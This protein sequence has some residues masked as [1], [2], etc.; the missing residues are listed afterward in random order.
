MEQ[1]VAE[2]HFTPQ[3]LGELWHVDPNTIRRM[4]ANEDGVLVFGNPERRSHRRYYS[5]RIPTSVAARV[6][7]RLHERVQ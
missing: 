7:R 3:E 1:L 4:F 6:H 5:M 2:R